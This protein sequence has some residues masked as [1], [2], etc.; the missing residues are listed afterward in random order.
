MIETPPRDVQ[1]EDAAKSTLPIFEIL[2]AS[3]SNEV[4]NIKDEYEAK[5][6]DLPDPSVT[7]VSLRSLCLFC[8]RGL[9]LAT[10]SSPHVHFQFVRRPTVRVISSV[11]SSPASLPVLGPPTAPLSVTRSQILSTCLLKRRVHCKV[12]A[13]VTKALS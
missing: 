6:G 8:V 2:G 10:H 12:R 9:R 4:A 7:L 3:V 5:F 11:I 1:D 13:P